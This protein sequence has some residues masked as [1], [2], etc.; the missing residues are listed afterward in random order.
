MNH[1]F[2][3]HTNFDSKNNEYKITLNYNDLS[4]K[5]IYEDIFKLINF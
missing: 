1:G 3:S 5:E 2:A 4:D